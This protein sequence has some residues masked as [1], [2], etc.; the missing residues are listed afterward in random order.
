[1]I[2]DEP[3]GR[4]FS[5]VYD[6]SD[7][8]A[9]YRSCKSCRRSWLWIAALF[10]V[11]F[12]FEALE[13]QLGGSLILLALAYVLLGVAVLLSIYFLLPLLQLRSRRKNGWD[14]PMDVRLDVDGV[15]ALHPSQDLLVRWAAI[16]DIVTNNG[17][18][19]LFTSPGCAIILPRR[20]FSSERHF[21]DW[22]DRARAYWQAAKPPDES[23]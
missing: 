10:V 21:N 16:K 3:K 23:E 9:L 1:M 5:V 15:A 20:V 4:Y 7:L 19:L 8:R 13:Q 22:S 6:A 2:G 18:L 14:V 17:R 11:L 12:A